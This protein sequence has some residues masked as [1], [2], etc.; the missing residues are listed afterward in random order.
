MNPA[1]GTRE[2]LENLSHIHPLL[3]SPQVPPISGGKESFLIHSLLTLAAPGIEPRTLCLLGNFHHWATSPVLKESALPPPCL[4]ICLLVLL[5]S[6]PSTFK[7]HTRTRTGT[8]A[9]L[10]RG[11]HTV[12]PEAFFMFSSLFPGKEMHIEAGCSQDPQSLRNLKRRSHHQSSI[13]QFPRER[14]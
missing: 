11:C 3:K 14:G 13:L 12:R 6:F 7:S 10:L 2:R 9:H 8:H 4:H 1:G 5:G